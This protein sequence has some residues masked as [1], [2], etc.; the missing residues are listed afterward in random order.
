MDEVAIASPSTRQR[1][2][3]VSPLLAPALLAVALIGA[4]YVVRSQAVS[5]P[6][7]QQSA[8]PTSPAIEARWGARVTMLGVSGDGGFVDFRFIAVDPDKALD[9]MTNSKKLPVLTAEDS[10][11]V[12]DTTA[13]M[14]QKHGLNAGETYFLLYLNKNGAIKKGTPVTISFGALKL[15]HVVAQ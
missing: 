13:Q 11:T 9:M 15:R 12:I 3:L 8:M 1:A 6:A 7:P 14:A 4:M 10:G 5:S 2:W